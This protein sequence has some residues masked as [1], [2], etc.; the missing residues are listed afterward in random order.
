MKKPMFFRDYSYRKSL[1]P[2]PYLRKLERGRSP[3][4]IQSATGFSIG[5]PGWGLLYYMVLASHREN[6]P[7]TII[8]TGSNFG[9]TTVLLAQALIDARVKDPLVMSFELDEENLKR[10]RL[11]ARK[12]GLTDTIQFI[13]GNT[14]ESLSPALS[15][16]LSASTIRFAFLDASHLADDV[17]HEFETLLPYLAKDAL[18]VF[19]NTY[20]ISEGHDEPRV[21]S[22]LSTIEKRHA[23]RIIELPFVSWFTPGLAV[24][25]K[26]R[27]DWDTI[28]NEV[29]EPEGP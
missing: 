19:D 3:A 29:S 10:A 4:H 18:V 9:A 24:W 25:Q 12:S 26:N 27:P 23:G 8:E 13:P 17:R 15:R 16:E 14:R 11:T 2:V 20:P 1:L 21:A 6:G 5:Q 7:G 22:F 28:E